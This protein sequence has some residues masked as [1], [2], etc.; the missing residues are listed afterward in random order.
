VFANS[1]KTNEK[2]YKNCN[3]C[4]EQIGWANNK[5]YKIY[6]FCAGA[7]CIKK[8]YFWLTILRKS[9]SFIGV[10]KITVIQPHN[11]MVLFPYFIT[12]FD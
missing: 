1:T 12:R 6:N 10:I 8:Q 5:N 3:F 7:K 2:N 11:F 4:E 9:E